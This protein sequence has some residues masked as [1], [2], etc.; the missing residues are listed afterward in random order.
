MKARFSAICVAGTTPSVARA[1]SIDRSAA[2]RY[3][4]GRRCDAWDFR[5]DD[6]DHLV[7]PLPASSSR[8][9]GGK[10]V[11]IDPWFGNPTSPRRA[12]RRRS[13]RRAAR[14]PRPWRPHRR[15]GPR[16]RARLA[17]DLA[18]HPRDEPL[19]GPP[20][21][22]RQR[23]RHRH[24][25]GRHGRGRRAEGHDD[26]RRPLGR[27]LERR[28]ARRRSTSASRSGFVDRAGERLP[29]LL[30]RRHRRRSATCA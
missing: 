3:D 13:L 22:R 19:A 16:S 17:A 10:T 30:R 26:P 23:R 21:A 2:G 6:D 9:P 18:V 29:G 12:G 1:A 8:T 5:R 20:P 14:H 15:R 4:A 25:Q 27:R 7:R 28:G 24:E 11:L